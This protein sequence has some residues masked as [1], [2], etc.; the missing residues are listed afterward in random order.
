MSSFKVAVCLSGQARH[1]KTAAPNIKKFFDYS[2]LVQYHKNVP[3]ETD[4]F[5]HTW[6]V[7]TWRY[8]KQIHTSFYN[9]EHNDLEGIKQAFNPKAIKQETWAED[10]YVRAWDSMFYSFER[11]LLLK[12]EYELAN[13]ISYDAVIKARLD[14]VYDPTQQIPFHAIHPGINGLIPGMCY[15]VRPINKFTY[16]YN[17]NSFDDV[18]FYGDSRTMDLVGS[19]YRAYKKIHNPEATK[20]ITH[21][22]NVDPTL[23]YGPGCL[24]YDYMTRMGIHPTVGE[25]LIDYAVVRSTAANSNLDSIADFQKVK[26]HHTNWYLEIEDIKD[27]I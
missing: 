16:E 25:L 4:Y 10:L 19:L 1:W 5:I 2:N 24:L 17:Y 22:I 18:I 6:N 20:Q 23:F 27:Y 13:N 21:G 14:T 15:T 11:S 7:N 8:P 3:I 12:R 9:E 26:E